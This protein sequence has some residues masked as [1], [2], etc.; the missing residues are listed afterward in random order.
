MYSAAWVTLKNNIVFIIAQSG[1]RGSV[2]DHDAFSTHMDFPPEG[3]KLG[4]AVRQALEASRFLDYETMDVNK[5]RKFMYEEAQERDKVFLK[6]AMQLTGTKTEGSFNRGSKACSIDRVDDQ[7][8]IKP[9]MDGRGSWGK[10]QP[11][12]DDMRYFPVGASDEE[13][14]TAVIEAL[15]R[16]K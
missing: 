12:E 5:I 13:I 1:G 11:T 8:V 15:E 9:T 10:H 2:A 6:Q 4:A 14:Q 7:F 3:V 16:S